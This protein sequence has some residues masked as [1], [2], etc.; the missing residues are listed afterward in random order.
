MLWGTIRAFTVLSLVQARRYNLNPFIENL[1]FII[2][3]LNTKSFT[4]Y[5]C[6]ETSIVEDKYS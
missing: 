4:F 5:F 6:W 3:L 2:L 1:L